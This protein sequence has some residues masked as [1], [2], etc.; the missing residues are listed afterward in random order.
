MKKPVKTF[1][2][3]SIQEHAIIEFNPGFPYDPDTKGSPHKYGAVGLMCISDIRYRRKYHI[4]LCDVNY[5][6]IKSKYSGKADYQNIWRGP[7]PR[8]SRFNRLDRDE[9]I[10]FMNKLGYTLDEKFHSQKLGELIKSG[11]QSKVLKYINSH[12]NEFYPQK[13]DDD[14]P[15][16]RRKHD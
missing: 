13:N 3:L 14:V 8:E 2:I 5:G 11:D 9:I 7:V 10:E 15:R 4:V 6:K 16:K 1:R 12:W